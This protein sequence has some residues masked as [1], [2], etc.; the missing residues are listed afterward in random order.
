MRNR[1]MDNEVVGF[2]H[3]AEARMVMESP[4]HVIV[5]PAGE[6]GAFAAVCG[7]PVQGISCV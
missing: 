2:G 3:F 5:D 7:Q 4:D 1:G 6:S